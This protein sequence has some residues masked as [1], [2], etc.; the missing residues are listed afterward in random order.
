MAKLIELL[1]RVEE[2]PRRSGLGL[3][4]NALL[5]AEMRK[6]AKS[7]RA[8]SP[9]ANRGTARAGEESMAPLCTRVSQCPEASHLVALVL[10]A[11]GFHLKGAE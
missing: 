11:H 7:G 4:R 2:S 3:L 9:V 6:A 10:Y 5:E 1:K 8:T